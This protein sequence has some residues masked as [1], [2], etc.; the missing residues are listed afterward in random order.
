MIRKL[1]CHYYSSHKAALSLINHVTFSL[2]RMGVK[3]TM[4]LKM[5]NFFMAFPRNLNTIP[6]HSWLALTFMYLNIG[7]PE[8]SNFSNSDSRLMF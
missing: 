8:A 7:Q 1:K 6:I 2:G 4:S 5:T 3:V